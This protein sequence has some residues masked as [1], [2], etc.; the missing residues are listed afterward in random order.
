MAGGHLDFEFRFGKAGRPASDEQPMRILVLADLAGEGER[1]VP[2]SRRVP[3]AVDVDNIERV[4]ARI[5]PRLTI[6]LDIPEGAPERVELSFGHLDELHPD[7]LFR[8]AAA[9]DGQRRLR[10]ELLDPASFP[11]AAAALGL[12]IEAAAPA[13]AGRESD[14]DT[15]S[16]LLGRAPAQPGPGQPNVVERLLHEAV[17]AHVVANDGPDRKRAVADFDGRIAERM[18]RILRHPAFQGLET[19][20]RGVWQL[21]TELECGDTLQVSVLDVSRDELR[22]DLLE[23]AGNALRR[24]LSGP[25]TEEVG[26]WSLLA[27]DF[28]FAAEVSDLAMLALLARLAGEAGAPFLAAGDPSLVGCAGPECLAQPAQWASLGHD[29]A[30]AWQ[31]LRESGDA[32]WLGLAMPH[33]LVRLPYGSATDPVESFA[34]EELADGRTH[35]HYLWG[36]P[37]YALAMLVGQAFAEDGWQMAVS[38]R[39][40]IT[41][42][43]SHVYRDEEGEPRQQP[44]AEV[45]LS[46]A[47]AESLLDRGIMPL[48]SYRNRDAVRLLRW[49]SVAVPARAL[50]GVLDG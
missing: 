22:T 47:A 26:P 50:A 7:A 37:V 5:S 21:A 25:D 15:L 11:R 41:S 28:N 32:V 4:M 36:N 29:V 18:R 16:R 27:G 42:L 23:N 6:E 12:A 14:S 10:E 49:Q 2:L 3:L 35:A 38:D 34:F 8:H 30:A 45:W 1:P 40:E 48:L 46:E 39:L 19:A 31:A 43:P 33:L 9:F 24:I 20:W 44:C 17:A 13:A